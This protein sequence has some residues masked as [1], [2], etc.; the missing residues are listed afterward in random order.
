MTNLGVLK[1]DKTLFG[2]SDA[3]GRNE[4]GDVL[5]AGSIFTRFNSADKRRE[6]FSSWGDLRIEKLSLRLHWKIFFV[7][8]NQPET[9]PALAEAK[10]SI[11]FVVERLKIIIYKTLVMLLLSSEAQRA[12]WA[13][14]VLFQPI[15]PFFSSLQASSA[16]LRTNRRFSSSS[17]TRKLLST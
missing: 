2:S 1:A 9:S 3:A 8:E 13:Q 15:L 16:L 6:Q 7:V 10:K 5:Q 17:R 12:E 14:H 11:S 4:R